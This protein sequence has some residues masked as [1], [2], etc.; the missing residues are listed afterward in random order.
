MKK[1]HVYE[2]NVPNRVGRHFYITEEG[3]R[4][5]YDAYNSIHP[6]CNT[7]DRFWERGGTTILEIS[8]FRDKGALPKDFMWTPY[9]IR[10]CISK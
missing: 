3:A 7:F 4:I 6:N 9:M 1:Y 2:D 8:H 10:E 5:I